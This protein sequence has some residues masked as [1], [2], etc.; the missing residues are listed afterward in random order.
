MS[1]VTVTRFMRFQTVLHVVADCRSMH[2]VADRCRLNEAAC[3]A[4]TCFR[5][6]ELVCTLCVFQQPSVTHDYSASDMYSVL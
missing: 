3:C 2:V 6:V 5:H 1:F 4:A